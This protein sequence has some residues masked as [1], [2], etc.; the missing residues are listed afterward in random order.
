MAFRKHPAICHLETKHGVELGIPIK[1]RTMQVL[2]K[3][4]YTATMEHF[5]VIILQSLLP[6][7]FDGWIYRCRKH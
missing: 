1:Q 5:L 3:I 2:Y 7:F 6:Q 4:Y